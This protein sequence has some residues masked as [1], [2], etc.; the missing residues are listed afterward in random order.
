MIPKELLLYHGSAYRETKELKPGFMHT[1]VLQQWD[2]TETNEWLYF[3]SDA[4]EA[5]LQALAGAIAKKYLLD[6]FQYD[7]GKKS[8]TV[9][10]TKRPE[11]PDIHKV[12]RDIFTA[13]MYMYVLRAKNIPGLVAN[14]NPHNGMKTE[15][16]TR[17]VVDLDKLE[18]P[19]MYI[20]V[21]FI[22]A[23]LGLS[24]DF[25]YNDQSK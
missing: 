7:M 17:Q 9:R 24:V 20:P 11:D 21:S 10:L 8:L 23:T 6:Q 15:Y 16:K 13:R 18:N 19:G 5:K 14:N 3:T 1:G 2:Q 25:I 12:S 4:R 22:E